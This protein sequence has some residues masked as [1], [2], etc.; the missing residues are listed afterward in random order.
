[1]VFI[2]GALTTALAM[3]I[4][5][6]GKVKDVEAR[7]KVFE[8]DLGGLALALADERRR[9]DQR[10]DNVRE[11]AAAVLRIAEKVLEQNTRL[12]TIIDERLPK[13]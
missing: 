3:Y 6:Y 9:T 13:L 7:Q 10:I 1:M 5:L 11:A 8:K 4:A 12:F 2:S